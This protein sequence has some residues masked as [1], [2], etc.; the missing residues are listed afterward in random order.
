[1]QV[2]LRVVVCV[3]GC[4]LH[5]NTEFPGTSMQREPI[6]HLSLLQK[7]LFAARREFRYILPIQLMCV[8]RSLAKVSPGDQCI[9]SL[10]TSSTYL[11]H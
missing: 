10:F 1:M 5:R 11:S 8:V 4:K 9:K 7:K 2:C 3:G 6:H